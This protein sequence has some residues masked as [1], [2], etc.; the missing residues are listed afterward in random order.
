MRDV[1]HKTYI[2]RLLCKLHQRLEERKDLN[3]GAF[4]R[5]ASE[6]MRSS[7]RTSI[8][9]TSQVSDG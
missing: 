8:I 7:V 1:A 9:L 4:D 6:T 3:I 2:R 5:K